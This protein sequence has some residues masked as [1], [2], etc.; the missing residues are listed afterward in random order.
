MSKDNTTSK[1]TTPENK[2]L[3]LAQL[4]KALKIFEFVRP[5]RWGIAVG[6]FLLFLSSMVFM[7]FPF[8][9]G[10]LINIA[11]GRS[12]YGVSL[13]QVGFFLMAVLIGQGF[14]SYYRVQLFATISEKGIADV[15]KALY[16]KIITLP[17]VFFEKNRTGDLVSRLTADVEKLYNAFSVTIAE[18]VRQIIVLISG[19]IILAVMAPK[20]SLVMLATFPVIVIGAMFFGKKIKKLSQQRQ[21]E[22]A[23]SNIV[24]NETMTTIQ[25]VKAFTNELFETLRYGKAVDNTVAVSLSFARGRALFT[26]FIVS[27]LFGGLFFVIWMGAWLLSKGDMDAGQLV[28]FVVYTAVIGGAIAGLGNFYTELVGAIGAT[29]RIREILEEKSE[30]SMPIGVGGFSNRQVIQNHPPTKGIGKRLE[31][32]IEFKDVHF[33]YPTRE[34]V[35]VL[36][37][38][39]ISVAAGEKLALVG[40]SGAGKSTVI[41][42]LLKFYGVLDGDITV[43]GQSIY[44][45]DTTDYRRNIA[46]VPQ[47]VLLFGGTIRENILYGKPDATEPEILEA[48]RQANALEFIERFPDGLDTVV[49]ERGIKLSGGQRQRIAIARAILKDPAILLLDEATSSL[50]AESEKVVQE[51]LDKLMEGRTSIIIAHRLATV[52]N[53]DKICVLDGG[54]IVES[55]THEELSMIADGLY[56]SLSKLQFQ[57]V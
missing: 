43:D 29:E 44:S 47:E 39:N 14:V 57:H 35:K 4:R 22:L 19:I 20:L 48:A 7:V 23:Q 10:E 9:S 6:L 55:G 18:F 56:N 40:P 38:I 46:L 12:K 50:D 24:L 34:D 49:G 33:N 36:K 16:S 13:K 52:R 30:V 21:E 28:S 53:V 27:V 25:V 3:N 17:I 26:V 45:M 54:Q 2:K 32:R 41:Q 51:A 5:Y 42:L 8:L 37:G 31:G 11:Q 1:P 15:R